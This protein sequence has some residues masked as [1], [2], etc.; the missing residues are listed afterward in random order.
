[1]YMHVGTHTTPLC[2][3]RCDCPIVT[4]DGQDRFHL[5]SRMLMAPEKERERERE[6]VADSHRSSGSK[7]KWVNRTVKQPGRMRNRARG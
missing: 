2:L 6:R 3:A 4:R 5:W 7:R 1:M